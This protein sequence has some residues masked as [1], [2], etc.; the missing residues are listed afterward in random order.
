[1]TRESDLARRSAEIRK[2][3]R[4][5]TANK[6]TVSQYLHDVEL[7]MA[8]FQVE[9]NR[10]RTSIYTIERKRDRLKRNAELYKSLLFPIHAVPSEILSIIFTFSCERN[11]LSGSALPSALRLSMV[12]GRWRDII[13]SSPHL[14][15]NVEIDF[16]AWTKGSD[17]M[18]QLSELYLT[19][20]QNSPLR[21]F[22]TLPDDDYA[23]DGTVSERDGLLTTLRSIIGQCERWEHFSLTTLPEDFPSAIFE[24]I[25]G[26][27]PL[28]ESLHLMKKGSEPKQWRQLSDYFGICPALHTLYISP[29][30]DSHPGKRMS[31][32]WSQI[33]TLRLCG[34]VGIGRSGRDYTSHL[35]QN[36]VKTLDILALGHQSE[37]DGVF[38]HTTLAGITSLRIWDRSTDLRD[39]WP[40]WDSTCLEAFLH[41]SSCTITSLHLK[42]LPIIDVQVLSLLR[43]IP[44]ITCLCIEEFRNHGQNR[45]VTKPFLDGLTVSES[46][47]SIS[48]SHFL[49]QLTDLKLVV[50]A[51]SLDANGFLNALSSRWLP[52]PS[53]ASDLGVECLRRVAIVVILDLASRREQEQKGGHLDCLECFRDAGMRIAIT[54]GSRSELYPKVS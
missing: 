29:A 44:S 13:F 50:H 41:R 10:L 3:F 11:V 17:V 28:L 47:P 16:G 40:T 4:S 25:R 19:R 38:K 20:S 2:F 15:S 37:V 34:K 30:P 18:T 8:E 52:D 48:P 31:L 35:V 39:R 51:K 33:K 54:Y 24:S 21:L 46:T 43:M 49:P 36:G 45:I 26:R 22:L 23:Y 5:T 32:P 6:A 42:S 53:H 27:V 12:C 9:I 7:E 14:W 1:M